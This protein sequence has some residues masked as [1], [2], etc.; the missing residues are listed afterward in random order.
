MRVF[1]IDDEA[2]SRSIIKHYLNEEFPFCKVVGE[3][4][5]VDDSV[6]QLRKLDIDLLFLD[7]ELKGGMGFEILEALGS[8]NFKIVFITAYDQF[9]IDAIKHNALDYLLKPLDREEF[10]HAVKRYFDP[11]R[12]FQAVKVLE[13]NEP[14]PTDRIYIPTLN[15]FRMVEVGSIIR[16]EADG[17]YTHFYLDGGIDVLVSKTL[18][19][20]ENS[21]G[22]DYAFVR[23]HQ[24]HLVNTSYIVEYIRGR[25]G[26]VLLKDGKRLSVSESKR[27]KLLS[28]LGIQ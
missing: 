11:K 12:G 27:K 3:S 10:S 19:T 17:N 1:I 21:L 9:A 13:E 4:G 22:E 18:K 14:K 8:I 20:Y 24:T 15:G 2:D 7:V 6:N 16:C 5:G 28:A 25:G 23:I 26:E